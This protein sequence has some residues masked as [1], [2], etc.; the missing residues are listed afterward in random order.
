MKDNPKLFWQYVGK[1]VLAKT[2][3]AYLVMTTEADQEIL[4]KSYQQKAEIL[5]RL[6]VF[7]SEPDGAIPTLEPQHA[8]TSLDDIIVTAAKVNDKLRKLKIDKSPGPDAIHP[9][10]LREASK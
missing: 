6:G 4:T 3:V 5:G 7:T 2:G 9:K 8:D 10:I 1:T